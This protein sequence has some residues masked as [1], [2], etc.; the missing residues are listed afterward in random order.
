VLEIGIEGAEG[1]VELVLARLA[2]A[3]AAA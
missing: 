3:E 2:R 1:L